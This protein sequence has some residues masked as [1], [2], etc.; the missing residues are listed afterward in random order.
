MTKLNTQRNKDTTKIQY[1][2]NG[3]RNTH[4]CEGSTKTSWHTSALP[5]R[6]G[7]D[8]FGTFF[9]FAFPSLIHNAT[10]S[11]VVAPQN[12]YSITGSD[13]NCWRICPVCIAGRFTSYSGLLH[14]DSHWGLECPCKKRSLVL[15]DECHGILLKLV[16]LHQKIVLGSLLDFC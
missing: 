1:T 2:R 12:V 10:T 6:M 3:N 16:H 15:K 11:P 7:W 4:A 13:L 14:S 9:V 5:A 8:R